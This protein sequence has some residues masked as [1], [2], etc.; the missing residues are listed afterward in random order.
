M[1]EP[2]SDFLSRWSRRKALQQEETD[3]LTISEGAGQEDELPVVSEE[4]EA[5]ALT[6]DDMPPLETLGE[7]DSYSGFLSPEVSE[8]LRK[9]AL[10]QLFHGAGFNIRDG[11]DDYDEDFTIFKPLG[12]IIT[13]DM[14]HREE[15][16]ERKAKEALARKNEDSDDSITAIAEKDEADEGPPS[17]E[18]AYDADATDSDLVEHPSDV[19]SGRTQPGVSETDEKVALVDQPI[20]DD[21]SQNPKNSKDN[22]NPK[23]NENNS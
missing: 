12:D 7:D 11:L 22:E 23:N 8:K 3:Q 21:S 6:D 20:D 19:E 2:R 13:A 5:P 14:R 4:E 17:D 9:V 16:L 15:M 10:R 1:S 18:E